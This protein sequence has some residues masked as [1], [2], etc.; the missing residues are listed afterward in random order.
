MYR[1][2]EKKLGGKYT[3]EEII[4]TLKSMNFVSLKG[5]GY[6]PTYTR[7]K[8]TDQLHEACGFRTDFEFIS[9]SQMRTIQKESKPK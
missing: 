4:N 9:K 6:M 2:L 5:Q 8:L 3:C 1:F 7:T